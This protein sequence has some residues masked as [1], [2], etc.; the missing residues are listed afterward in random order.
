M[1]RATVASSPLVGKP[2]APRPEERAREDTVGDLGGLILEAAD[3]GQEHSALPLDLVVREPRLGGHL[4]EQREEAR[5]VTRQAPRPELAVLLVGAALDAAPG[6]L[7]GAR[8]L[9]GG[10]A[11]ASP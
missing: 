2:V 9:D 4:V 6:V 1:I 3:L 11:P 10:H 8:D 5:P 7:G